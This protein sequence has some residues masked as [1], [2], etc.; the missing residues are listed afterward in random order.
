MAINPDE[1][2]GCPRETTNGQQSPAGFFD[3]TIFF[4][5]YNTHVIKI[6]YKKYHNFPVKIDFIKF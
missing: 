6:K 5:R 2:V 1:H 3:R 4:F